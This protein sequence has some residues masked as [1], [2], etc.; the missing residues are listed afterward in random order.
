M[1]AKTL[2]LLLPCLLALLVAASPSTDD[3]HGNSVCWEQAE[4]M[5]W[6]VVRL[7]PLEE[8][9]EEE[10]EEPEAGC[11]GQSGGPSWCTLFTDCTDCGVPNRV[12]VATGYITACSDPDECGWI[13]SPGT[14]SCTCN[15]G[16]PSWNQCFSC[17]THPPG[18]G[19]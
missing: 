4:A 18:T 12:T 10:E 2:A 6:A 15:S 7:A 3:T 13:G 1:S 9:E 16:Q 5:G 14:Q 8:E 19:V 17:T 11:V